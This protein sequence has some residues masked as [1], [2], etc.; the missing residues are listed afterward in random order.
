MPLTQ[1]TTC[2]RQFPNPADWFA[3]LETC[4]PARRAEVV[5]A[6]RGL[7]MAMRIAHQ[8]Q[9]AEENPDEY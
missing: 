3:H 2:G 7:D 4:S 5:T 1:C 8:S 6:M 9:S